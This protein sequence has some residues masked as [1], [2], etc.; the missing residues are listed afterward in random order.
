M[1]EAIT[2]DM[3]IHA[4]RREA[5]GMQVL[6]PEVRRAISGFLKYNVGRQYNRRFDREL[7]IHEIATSFPDPSDQYKYFRHAFWHAVPQWV[8]D[9]RRFFSQ[10]NRGFGENCF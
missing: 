2:S 10:E 8:R 1:K 9:H 4:T 3:Q 7:G 6:V 5:G